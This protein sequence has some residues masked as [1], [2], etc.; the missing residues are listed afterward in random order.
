VFGLTVPEQE[1]VTALPSIAVTGRFGWWPAPDD[2]R[3]AVLVMAA[4]RWKE[5]DAGYGDSVQLAEGIT[6]AYYRQFPATVQATIE[7]YVRRKVALA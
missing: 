7:S 5:R 4:R 3:D 6:V 2:I 1:P